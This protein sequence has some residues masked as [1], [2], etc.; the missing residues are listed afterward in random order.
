VSPIDAP[1]WAAARDETLLVQVCQDCGRFNLPASLACPVCGGELRWVPASGRGRVHTFTVFHKAYHPGFA[2]QLPYNVSVIELDEGPFVLSN[3][4][5]VEPEDLRIG[6]DVE[7][8]FD[9]I[10]DDVTLPR[11]RRISA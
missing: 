6:D 10:T 4:V 11:F 7:V 8:V 1:Y 2:D 5:D 3:V 9:A